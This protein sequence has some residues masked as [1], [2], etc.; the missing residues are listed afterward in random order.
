MII[1]KIKSSE[2]IGGIN[3]CALMT[4]LNNACISI[5]KCLFLFLIVTMI[6]DNES[7]SEV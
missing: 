4:D 5:F 1:C 6:V 3:E 2:C 7:A